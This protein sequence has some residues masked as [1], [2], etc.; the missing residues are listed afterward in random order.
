MK[1]EQIKYAEDYDIR[2]F[3]EF[4]LSGFELAGATQQIYRE[5]TKKIVAALR[6]GTPPWQSGI[7]SSYL[8]MPV[9]IKSK[10][11]YHGVNIFLL[12]LSEYSSRWWGTKKQFTAKGAKIKKGEKAQTI[13]F[14]TLYEIE[15]KNTG[16]LINV[17]VLRNY[18]VYN[19]EQVEGIDKSKFPEII[20]IHNWK[21]VTLA[22]NIAND[23]IKREKIKLKHDVKTGAPHYISL[24]DEVHLYPKKAYKDK[25][26]Y[27]EAL[28]H[29]LGHSTGH[30]KRLKRPF[31]VKHKSSKEL[32]KYSYEELVAEFTSAFLCGFCKID[33][34]INN[35]AAYIKGWASQLK[36]NPWWC[37]T[38]AGKA[39][40]AADLIL[41]KY[42]KEAEKA[43]KDE[44]KD[45]DKSTKPK[46]KSKP[47]KKKTRNKKKTRSKKKTSKPNKPAKVKKPTK[48]KSKPK[49]TEKPRK[50]KK[51][52]VK[53]PAKKKV[54]KPAPAEPKPEPKKVSAKEKFVIVKKSEFANA[55]KLLRILSKYSNKYLLIKFEDAKLKL[56]YTGEVGEDEYVY[57]NDGFIWEIPALEFSASN[58]QAVVE[59]TEF[60]ADFKA[61][62]KGREKELKITFLKD[63]LRFAL[64]KNNFEV[65]RLDTSLVHPPELKTKTVLK[66]DAERL[67]EQLTDTRPAVSKEKTRFA[68]DGIL[69]E[70]DS[71]NFNTVGTDGKRL[72]L[73]SQKMLKNFK[74]HDNFIVEPRFAHFI[75]KNAKNISNLRLNSSVRA[76]SAGDEYIVAKLNI[77]NSEI[78]FYSK[79]LPGVFP[80]YKTV[81]PKKSTLK[82][83]LKLSD[84]TKVK[85]KKDYSEKTAYFYAVKIAKD[86]YVGIA[87]EYYDWLNKNGWTELLHSNR[88]EDFDSGFNDSFLSQPLLY[89]D[90]KRTILVMPYLAFDDAHVKKLG[91]TGNLF[92]AVETI[93]TGNKSLSNISSKL[94]NIPAIKLTKKEKQLALRLADYFISK[95]LTQNRLAQKAENHLIISASKNAKPSKR[96]HIIEALGCLIALK[97]LNNRHPAYT[98]LSPVIDEKIRI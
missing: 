20:S 92:G 60:L 74:L 38:A 80:D 32:E 26:R 48:K 71:G 17:P 37:V 46:K 57:W 15:D 27:Y 70:T 22:E 83:K 18:R 68:I 23:Y 19:L 82:G 56:I 16:D 51:V 13:I 87:E 54:E 30:E 9:N 2:E 21:P 58:E 64:G 11:N 88:A 39:Q 81:I 72:L 77:N 52:A 31:G 73:A 4:T 96:R 3:G 47:A 29:E 43:L 89:S 79:L 69:F 28:F 33:R 98:R 67:I 66:L 41:G 24:T 49:S 7:T 45:A 97:R 12:G 40:K 86:R 8:G 93:Q 34:T 61:N 65:D 44:L 5:V 25:E 35:A 95:K 1:R 42:R 59:I 6:N 75:S 62:I 36:N 76:N 85:H 63:V 94:K 78:T 55:L 50:K 84:F 91:S 10:K 53:K 90:S 14:W